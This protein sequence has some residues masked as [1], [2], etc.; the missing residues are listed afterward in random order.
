M[1][2]IEFC[3]WKLQ[4]LSLEKY[5]DHHNSPMCGRTV[6]IRSLKLRPELAELVTDR[7]SVWPHP[8]ALFS[9]ARFLRFLQYAQRSLCRVC[10]GLLCQPHLL[11]LLPCILSGSHTELLIVVNTLFPSHSLKIFSHVACLTSH[12]HPLRFSSSTLSLYPLHT[13][14][15]IH[16]SSCTVMGVYLAAFSPLLWACQRQIFYVFV[17]V[18]VCLYVRERESEKDWYLAE[19]LLVTPEN[20]FSPWHPIYS[21]VSPCEDTF[22]PKNSNTWNINRAICYPSLSTMNHTEKYILVSKE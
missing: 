18:S 2:V 20:N 9:Y 22:F 5:F 16:I 13:A 10:P 7:M 15:I 19:M 17:C 4:I 11:F 21:P 1:G 6:D 3:I 12:F 14:V 8:Q